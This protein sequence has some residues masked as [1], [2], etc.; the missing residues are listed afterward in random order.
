MGLSV[1]CRMFLG[2]VGVS[3][4]GGCLGILGPC[5][6]DVNVVLG[7]GFG[8]RR[9]LLAVVG[10]WGLAVIIKKLLVHF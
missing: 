5:C 6:R 8:A 9:C 1:F 3:C 2:C 4:S 7:G 10:E